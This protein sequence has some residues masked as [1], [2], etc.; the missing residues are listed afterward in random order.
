MKDTGNAD[1]ADEDGGPE[2]VVD[3]S[4]Y[5]KS[6]KKRN[7]DWAGIVKK[8][9]IY[10]RDFLHGK[11]E[12]T[13][14]KKGAYS[15]DRNEDGL[16]GLKALL[17]VFEHPGKNANKADEVLEEQDHGNGNFFSA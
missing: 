2:F 7:E 4:L 17:A 15:A 5:P 13:K 1:E 6:C 16:L 9:C 8:H 3:R 12:K 14:A 11:K 10:K